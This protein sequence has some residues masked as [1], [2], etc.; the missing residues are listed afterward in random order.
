MPAR[1]RLPLALLVCGLATAA[2]SLTLWSA[3][4]ND[5]RDEARERAGGTAAALE[6]RAGAA[7]LALQGVRAAYDA[8]S[9]VGPQAFSTFARVPLAR[10]EIAAVGWVPLVA[11]AQRGEVE[12]TEQIRIEAPA[13]VPFTFPLVRQE[14]AATSLDVL[15]LGSDPSLGE[16]L[17]SARTTGQPR[18]SAPVRLPGDGRIGVYAFVP[19]FAKGLPLRTSDAAPR[20]PHRARRRRDRLERA[21]PRLARPGFP[22]A[23][24]C[25][26]PTARPCSPRAPAAARSPTQSS[27][28]RTW[29]VSLAPA[30]ASPVAPIG[31]A[32][33]GVALMLLLVGAS[34]RLRRR[35][36]SEAALETTL[37]HE[38]KTSAHALA[39]AE[40]TI[41]EEQ[42]TRRLVADA[43]DALVLEID[44]DG[45]IRSCSAA[46]EQL[47]GY[48]ADGA[49]RHRG[50]LA[51]APG[52]PALARERPAA[53]CAQGR[54]LRRARRPPA[55]PPRRARVRRRRRHRPPRPGCLDPP[56]RR[57]ANP[58]CGRAR[59]RPRRAV[60][61]RRRGDGPRPRASTPP[62]SS[63]SRRVASARSSAPASRAAPCTSCPARRS[64][65]RATSP[66]RRSSGPARPLPEPRPIRIGAR[67]WGALVAEGGDADRLL[68][69]ALASQPA[70]RVRRRERTAGSARNARPAHEPSRPPRLPRAA[71]LRVAARTAPRARALARPRQHRR[72][73]ADQ[74]RARAPRRRPGAGRG[75]PPARRDRPERRARLPA[76]RRPLRLGP[77]RDGRAQ[78][79]DR[80]RAGTTLARRR[81]DRRG[82]LRHRLGR[83]LRLRG[84]GRR[85]RA[86]RAR[87]SRTRPREV[88]GRRRDVQVQRRARRRRLGARGRGRSRPQPPARARTRARRGGSRHRRTLG[89]RLAPV[90]EAGALLRLARRPRDQ[91]RSGRP[92]ARRRQARH[93]RGGAPQAGP[94]LRRAS[95]SRFATTRTRAP[96][97]P[98]GRSTRSSSAGSATT[99]SAGTAR[100]IRTA[101]PARR[102]RPAHGCS[103]S[104]KPGT[105]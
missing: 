58:G 48:T 29:R 102:S 83:R 14:P 88:L 18:L 53:V 82:R 97:S 7:V 33:A 72:L 62:P 68:Q 6:Q 36:A 12:A 67:L 96:R 74:R 85:R 30:S 16:A 65:S 56:D 78:R 38:R 104:Q 98:S 84:R 46:A 49:R 59:A 54:N 41:G 8:S 77:P 51:P 61:R 3:E 64:R 22:T 92:P 86:A 20:R 42:Q 103:R 19:V 39:R 15:D 34:L 66:P 76:L 28:A 91:A 99:T 40:S 32:F 10:P 57:A 93:R 80:R 55:R 21:G 11:A 43:S 89:A 9:S 52:R 37:V 35:A 25:A 47:L 1:L 2:L 60:L 105:R 44:R 101:S 45:L 95:S 75:R 81:P 71:A 90:R 79:L 69:L 4:K 87:R 17:N 70:D 100:A 26:S 23:S 50:L 24:T 5:V 27:V 63:A 94:A 31:T 13:G 73:Q